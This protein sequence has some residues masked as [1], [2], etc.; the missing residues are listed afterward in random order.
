MT[1]KGKE[2]F[3]VGIKQG[4]SVILILEFIEEKH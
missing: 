1:I 2:K 3:W 4:G